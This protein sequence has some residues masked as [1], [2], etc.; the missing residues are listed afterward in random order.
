MKNT[1]KVL[2]IIEDIDTSLY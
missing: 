2:D 1:L